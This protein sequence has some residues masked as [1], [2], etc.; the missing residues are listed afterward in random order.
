[1]QFNFAAQVIRCSG[2]QPERHC[3]VNQFL[4]PAGAMAQW[5]SLGQRRFCRV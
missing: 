3:R 4:C 2:I 5:V 1:M